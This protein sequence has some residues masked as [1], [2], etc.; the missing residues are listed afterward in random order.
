MKVALL[1]AGRIGTTIA[2]WL[3]NNKFEVTVADSSQKALNP[4]R[5]AGIQTQTVNVNNQSELIT[6]LKPHD[7]AINALPYS[8]AVTT[9]KACASSGTHY[10]DLTEDVAATRSIQ[11]LAKTTK[12]VAFMPQ[13]GLAPGFIGIAAHNLASSFDTLDEV[14]MRVGALPQYPNNELKYNMTWSPEGLINEYI[15]PCDAIRS[16]K[17]TSI[18]ALADLENLVING[19]EYEAFNTSGGIGTLFESLKGKVRNMDYK[20][21]RYPGHLEKIRFLMHDLRLQEDTETL[22][23]IL[24]NAIPSTKQDVVIVFVAVSGW[25]NGLYEQKILTRTIKASTN[26]TAIQIATT[27][28]ICAVID[29][30][31]EGK[32]PSE[33]FIGQEK[34]CLQE[35]LENRFGAAYNQSLAQ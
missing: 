5:N 25:I 16:G 14:K 23:K 30:F 4:L 11:E 32:L 6:F 33:G 31:R 12:K 21:I 19:V 10:F 24:A 8:A 27:S 22:H 20:S 9:A 17:Q 15:Q 18:A 1:G 7:A 2:Q 26:E 34:V 29:L 13:C 3:H 35:F 28:G